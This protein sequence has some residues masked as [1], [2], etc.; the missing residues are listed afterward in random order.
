ML[1]S[2]SHRELIAALFVLVTSSLPSYVP[3]A[4]KSALL[5][6]LLLLTVV[7]GL[8]MPSFNSTAILGAGQQAFPD[9]DSLAAPY[10]T[11]GLAHQ[12]LFVGAEAHRYAG[13][14]ATHVLVYY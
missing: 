7:V 6:M 13:P 5:L 2:S 3:R 14:R 4:K 8:V 12:D 1:P 10:D 11:T 9:Y